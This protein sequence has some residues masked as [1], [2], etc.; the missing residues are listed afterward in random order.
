MSNELERE[1]LLYTEFEQVQRSTE[2]QRLAQ[3]TREQQKASWNAMAQ[4]LQVKSCRAVTEGGKEVWSAKLVRLI[5]CSCKQEVARLAK[6]KTH[7]AFGVKVKCSSCMS[8]EVLCEPKTGERTDKVGCHQCAILKIKCDRVVMYLFEKFQDVWAA[9]GHA[10]AK[11]DFMTWYPTI[12]KKKENK[13]VVLEEKEVR[14]AVSKRK[15][16]TDDEEEDEGEEEEKQ[17]A[18][19]RTSSA[20]GD[21]EEEQ[22]G[23]S[24]AQSKGRKTSAARG[25]E[26]EEEEEEVSLAKSKGKGKERPISAVDVGGE[27]EEDDEEDSGSERPS[28]SAMMTPGARMTPG[29]SRK[30]VTPSAGSSRGPQFSAV[31]LRK[32]IKTLEEEL[33]K[34][35]AHSS[36]IEDR[37]DYYK[38]KHLEAEAEVQKLKT[39]A[40]DFL[41]EKSNF[42]KQ[43]A[44]LDNLRLAAKDAELWREEVEVLKSDKEE[45]EREREEF[46]KLREE[47]EGKFAAIGR[48]WE[49]QRVEL[50][51]KLRVVE[52][53][54]E[55]GRSLWEEQMRGFKESREAMKVRMREFELFTKGSGAGVSGVDGADEVDKVLAEDGAAI[56][57]L[58][59]ALRGHNAELREHLEA[60]RSTNTRVWMLLEGASREPAKAAEYYGAA[61]ARAG[62]DLTRA[63]LL[64]GVEVSLSLLARFEQVLG[65]LKKGERGGV[66]RV[67]E[68]LGEGL[69]DRRKRHRGPEV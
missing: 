43:A 2:V 44:E 16:G 30:A 15:V 35:K 19:G 9:E 1:L 45:L 33:A 14:R 52:Q 59:T 69:E 64:S 67:A 21:D 38:R 28:G 11:A 36:H 34:E 23:V 25:D 48:E 22:A 58:L 53:E 10:V 68:E 60:F 3:F 61:K 66:K 62:E 55:A 4:K 13:F 46:L 49:V 24:P 26:E 57:S 40:M 7:E 8:K 39:E 20:R 17:S 42:A 31:V 18:K 12:A 56:L 63:L 32:R 41:V 5:F 6:A 65:V 51:E 37:R 47:S 50:E 27:E 29:L 54:T